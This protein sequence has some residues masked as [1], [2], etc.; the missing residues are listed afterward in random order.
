MRAAY[1]CLAWQLLG[2]HADAHWQSIGSHWT[3]QFNF[4]LLSHPPVRGFD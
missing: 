1:Y 2:R 3:P 4:A